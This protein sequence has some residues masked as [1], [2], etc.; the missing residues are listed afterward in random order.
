MGGGIGRGLES[1]F[2]DDDEVDEVGGGDDD[3]DEDDGGDKSIV[4][5]GLAPLFVAIVAVVVKTIPRASS[6]FP[7]SNQKNTGKRSTPTPRVRIN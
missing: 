1:R 7:V 6:Q 5:S 4:R 3:E 2:D